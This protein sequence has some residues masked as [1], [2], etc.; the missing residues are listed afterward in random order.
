MMERHEFIFPHDYTAPRPLLYVRAQLATSVASTTL[1]D[2]A[3]SIRTKWVSGC[4]EWVCC[5][6]ENRVLRARIFYSALTSNT[7]PGKIVL[8]GVR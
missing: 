1:R 8:L 3:R 2:L 7:C 5:I 4:G 6:L